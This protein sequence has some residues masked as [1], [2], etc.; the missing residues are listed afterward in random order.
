MPVRFRVERRAQRDAFLSIPLSQNSSGQTKGSL[1]FHITMYQLRGCPVGKL[2]VL[3]HQNYGVYLHCLRVLNHASLNWL[4]VWV[5]HTEK[6]GF[7]FTAFLLASYCKLLQILVSSQE[8]SK[9]PLAPTHFLS[10]YLR[11]PLPFIT[12]ILAI[13]ARL[14]AFLVFCWCLQRGGMQCRW[15]GVG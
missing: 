5:I 15:G 1:T 7:Y 9:H 13:V 10:N 6:R 11:L 12:C 2:C 3:S 14:F 4:T 8:K